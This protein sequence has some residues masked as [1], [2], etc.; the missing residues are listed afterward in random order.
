MAGAVKLLLTMALMFSTLSASAQSGSSFRCKK[1]S[2][3]A[4]PS[5][6]IEAIVAAVRRSSRFRVAEVRRPTLD[7]HAP[8]DALEAFTLDWGGCDT[9]GGDTFWIRKGARGWCV[10]KKVGHWAAGP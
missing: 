3:C 4:L 8:R 9:G 10:L 7:E 6:D 1:R 2:I 5:H